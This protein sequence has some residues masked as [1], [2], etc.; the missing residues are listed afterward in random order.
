[1]PI[2]HTWLDD[3]HTLICV[4]LE[5]QV[6]YAEYYD[7]DALSCIMLD[8]VDHPVDMI[9][10]YTHQM[11]FAPGYTENVRQLKSL[12]HPRLRSAIFVGNPLSW[13]LFDLYVQQTKPVKFQYAYAKTM[14]E[15]LKLI[16][17]IRAGKRVT[18]RRRT[19]DPKWN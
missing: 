7:G 11:Y 2:T 9:C 19:I 12:D 5:G 18:K 16:D 15:A 3:A 8:G 17:R 13:E 14:K 1:M 10:D 6:E 4:T